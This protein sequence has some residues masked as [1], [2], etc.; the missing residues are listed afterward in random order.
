MNKTY[1]K[2]KAMSKAIFVI[3]LFLKGRH[4]VGF[5]RIPLETDETRW[6]KHRGST[7]NKS[8]L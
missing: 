7:Q 3:M 5:G 1:I 4:W 8:S 2:K 6:W